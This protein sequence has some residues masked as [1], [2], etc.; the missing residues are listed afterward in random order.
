[1]SVQKRRSLRGAVAREQDGAREKSCDIARGK[2][3]VRSRARGAA[4]QVLD[5]VG[6]EGTRAVAQRAVAH[7]DLARVAPTEPAIDSAR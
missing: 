3:R 2:P 6:R 7:A 4:R 1:M 5:A